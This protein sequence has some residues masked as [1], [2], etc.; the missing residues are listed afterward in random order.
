[1]SK[2]DDFDLHRATRHIAQVWYERMVADFDL[3]ANKE[4]KEFVATI[5]AFLPRDMKAEAANEPQSGGAIRRYTTAFKEPD[6]SR[7]RARGKRAPA[8]T[9]AYSIDD[10]DSE[11]DAA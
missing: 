7:G 2:H 5:G 1:M 3:V 6:A 10:T 11:D 4:L 9:V 8:P